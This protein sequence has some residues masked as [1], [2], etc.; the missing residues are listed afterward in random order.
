MV[1]LV[2]R[3]IDGRYKVLSLLGK[4]GM[5]MVYV[6]EQATVGRKVALKVLRSDMADDD[7]FAKRFLSEAKAIAS[8]TSHHTVTLHDFGVT[9]DGLLYYTME[10]LQGRAL[11]KI[12]RDEGPVEWKRATTFVLQALDSLEEAHDKGILHRDIKPENLFVV[13]QRDK[14][15]VVVLDFGIAKLSGDTS[16]EK[17]TR[18][19]MICGTPAYISP[20]QALGNPAVPASDLYALG[21]VL[22][23]MLAG[24]PPFHDTTPMK[25]LL[26]QLNE[27]PRR[28]SVAN[29]KVRIPVLLDAALMR[30]LAKTPEE[31]FR[32]ASEFRAALENALV[33]TDATPDT[34]Q[35]A[36][37]TETSSGYRG[38]TVRFAPNAPSAPEPGAAASIPE[39]APAPA[40]AFPADGRLS[41]GDSRSPCSGEETEDSPPHDER[42]RASLVAPRASRTVPI[43]VAAVV[44]AAAIAGLLLWHSWTAPDTEPGAGASPATSQESPPESTA[45]S[46]PGSAT[47]DPRGTP[48]GSGGADSPKSGP[49][50]GPAAA[51][52]AEAPGA[53]PKPDPASSLAA[54]PVVAVSLPVPAAPVAAVPADASTSALEH[55]VAASQP[56]SAAPLCCLRRHGSSGQCPC[57]HG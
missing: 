20:E 23:E 54:V 22:Y 27:L 47:L 7:T 45:P 34:V 42:G 43:A 13:Q 44:V 56:T 16:V 17:I 52:V 33:Q 10:L 9:S 38:V 4:G 32:T 21:I 55:L 46:S 24:V 6:A 49:G 3:D 41:P 51:P 37:M 36:P 29:D 1:D 5:G 19:G 39:R 26:K 18:T 35:M 8:L 48:T 25:V 2:G 11:S 28:V 53:T 30:V 15:H 50:L 57:I 31:R 40:P 12:I 14:E